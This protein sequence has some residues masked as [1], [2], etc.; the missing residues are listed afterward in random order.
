MK[1]LNWLKN[2]LDFII[3]PRNRITK[4][5][6]AASGG[7][8]PGVQAPRWPDIVFNPPLLFGALIV[9]T[10]FLIVLFGPLWAPVN[11]YIA[12]QYVTPHFENGVWI[13][14]PLDPSPPYPLGTDQW[15]NDILSMLLYGA[16]NTLV[17]C[18]FIT[19]ARVIVGLILGSLAGWFEGKF[20][21]RLIMGLISTLTAIPMLISSIILIFALDI[22]RGLIVFIISLALIGWTEIAQYIRGEILVIRQMPYIEGARSLGMTNL[23]IVVRQVW[24]NILPQLLILTF[25]E[26]GAVVLLLGELGFV[27][28]FIGGGSHIATG[29]DIVGLQVQRIAAVPEWGAM[30]AQGYRWLRTKPFIVFP[31]ALA[32][33]ITVIG[34][35]ALG[36][37][38]RRLMERHY[39]NTS[40]LLKKRMILVILLISWATVFTMNTTGPAPWLARVSR[41]F[42]GQEAYDHTAALANLPHRAPGHPDH[43]AAAQYIATQFATYGLQPGWRD[44]NLTHIYT[45]TTH[46][47]TPVTTPQLQLLNPDRSPQHTFQHQ[48]DFGFMIEG[49]A[50]SGQLT[51]PLTTITFDPNQR[52]DWSSFNQLDLRGRILLAHQAT[53]PP[54]FATEA[55]IR[56]AQAILWVTSDD[57]DAIRSQTQLA[58]PNRDYLR[59]PQHPVFRLRPAAADQILAASN[60]TWSD[61]YANTLTPTQTGPGWQT[62]NL[63]TTLNLSLQLT[64]PQPTPVPHVLGYLPG[65]DFN[66]ASELIIVVA[67]Y[68]T[69]PTTPDQPPFIGAN[70]NASGI[71]ILLEIARLWQEQEIDTRRP[72]LFI[73]WGGRHLDN[74]GLDN[75]VTDTDSF[76]YLASTAPLRPIALFQIDYAGYGGADLFL[77]PDTTPRLRRLVENTAADLDIS[78]NSQLP[79]YHPYTTIDRPGNAPWAYLA[80]TDGH[81]PPHQDTL[82]NIQPDKLQTM[83]QLLTL[84][85]STMVRQSGY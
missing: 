62:Y 58:F 68:D 81:L 46:L 27:G 31:P 40:F 32:F 35:N 34:F 4:I 16:R 49:H 25:F 33:F 79:P 28:I 38:L 85:L 51:A 20:I 37:G 9:T 82:D 6:R 41:A 80:W 70:H 71:S 36:E 21:D 7:P 19:M 26:L 63:P 22:R 44:E 24:P 39:V 1:P 12:G 84:T 75:F 2:L 83:G 77:H 53:A 23:E 45:A 76:R 54:D 65:S 56:G 17:A 42:T 8:A 69:L 30:L 18:L 10:L 64:N 50:G 29:D 74:N 57:R 55:F 11:P 52:F 59:T 60:H 13:E 67:H 15:G 3:N 72:V 61:F 14:P 5:R 66:L 73:A 43:T 78:I 47:V 48:I